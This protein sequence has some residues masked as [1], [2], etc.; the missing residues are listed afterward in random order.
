MVGVLK[1][2]TSKANQIASMGGYGGDFIDDTEAH[3]PTSP[4]DYVAIQALETTVVT[5]VGNIT[6]LT[7]VTV[8]TGSIIYGEF[9]SI[10]L[11]SGSVIAYLGG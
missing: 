7:S 2:K 10:T 9:T 8:P 11:T 1:I 5:A 6:G 3:T 4:Y